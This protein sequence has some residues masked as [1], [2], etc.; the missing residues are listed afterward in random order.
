MA[1]SGFT[2]ILIYGSGTATNT[3]SASNLTNSANGAELAINYA[4]GKLFYK[5]GSGNVQTIAS[6]SANAGT[7]SSVTITGGTINGT[8]VGATTASTGAFTTLS[9]SSTVSGTGFSTYL[10]SPP[11]IGGTTPAAGAFTTTTIG[12]SETLSYGTANGVAYLNGSKVLTTGS[13][14]TFDGTYFYAGGLRLRG[15]DTANTIYQSTGNLFITADAGTLAL[16]ANSSNPIAFYLNSAEQMRLTSTG[17]GIGTTI[18]LQKL[19]VQGDIRV[20]NTLRYY[21]GST[22]YGLMFANA[23][24]VGT[25]AYQGT[26]IYWGTGSGASATERM[27]IDS[28]GNLLVNG[29]A[30]TGAGKSN[31][32]FSAGSNGFSVVSTDNTTNASF[33]QFYANGAFCGNITRVG[34]TSAVLYGSASDYRL[35]TVIGAVANAGERIDALEPIEYDW[36]DGGRTRGFLAHQFAEV[37]PN[38]V[39][40]KKDAVDAEGKPVYQGMQASTPEV[41]ADLIAEIQSLRKRVAQL[42]SK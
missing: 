9:A 1:Q 27:R 7:F 35:K 18:P 32:Y 13:A 33:S 5:D 31:L 25:E 39:S 34:T 10:A 29:T 38:S 23:G 4:D 14:L 6:K 12:T 16:Q 36:K 42:E 24:A 21:V 41:M 11:A 20:A 28:S 26:Y 3:P 37:Y 15:L 30:T 40:G 8:S 17:L 2:P 22:Q 19:D